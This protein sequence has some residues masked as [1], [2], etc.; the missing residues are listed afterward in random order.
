[1][2]IVSFPPPRVLPGLRTLSSNASRRRQDI[3][4]VY[5]SS[6]PGASSQRT[7]DDAE[8]ISIIPGKGQDV[9]HSA[10][11]TE[12]RPDSPHST[13]ELWPV[14]WPFHLLHGKVWHDYPDATVGICFV[15]GLTGDRDSTW[16][17]DGQSKPWPKKLL[18]PN[19]D[20][21]RIIT[22]DYD[23]YVVR[24]SVAL[25][26]RLADHATN[27]FATLSLALRVS[28]L[29]ACLT[30]DWAAVILTNGYD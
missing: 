14:P 11:G 3:S 7:W 8:D 27:L 25:Q 5:R 30:R 28:Y 18:L 26:K 2:E 10:A 12:P 1:M 29:W 21:A 15:H 23:A 6:H 20:K 24:V 22:Y 13:D 16:T 19:L 17:A 9:A 4:P